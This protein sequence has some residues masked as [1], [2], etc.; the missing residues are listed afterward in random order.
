MYDEDKAIP[1]KD[2]VAKPYA[3]YQISAPYILLSDMSINLNFSN[4]VT[5]I[6]LLAAAGWEI[7]SPSYN[8]KYAF[9]LCKNPFFKPKMMSD[10]EESRSSRDVR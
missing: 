9:V 6:N 5:A 4:L 1:A 8:G 10:S 7:G 3:I 2:I